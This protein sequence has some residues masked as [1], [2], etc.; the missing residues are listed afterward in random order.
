MTDIVFENADLRVSFEA[1]SGDSEEI[2]LAFTGGRHALAGVDKDDFV[3]TN[4]G[5]RV[6]RDAYYVNDMKRSWYRCIRNDIVDVL[7]PRIDGRRVITLGNSLGGFGALMFSGLFDTCDVAIA[8]A[9]QYSIS[10]A[11]VPFETRW[12][13]FSADLEFDENDTCFLPDVGYEGCRKYVFCGQYDS[14]DLLHADL[15]ARAG[16]AETH[17]FTIANCGH[18]VSFKLKE[19]GVLGKLIETAIDVPQGAESIH[20]LLNEHDVEHSFRCAL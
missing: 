10:P 7:S 5:S 11:R 14:S 9:P 16:G 6:V 13:H 3:R 20:R 1:G 2:I 4:R 15:I 18:D 17:I 12:Q 8:F 19:R